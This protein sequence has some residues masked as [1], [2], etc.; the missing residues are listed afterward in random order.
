[1]LQAPYPLRY[2]TS[3]YQ[4][5]NNSQVERLRAAWKEMEDERYETLLQKF[6]KKGGSRNMLLNATD[7]EVKVVNDLKLEEGMYMHAFKEHENMDV[8]RRQKAN[9]PKKR[10]GGRTASQTQAMPALVKMEHDDDVLMGSQA[11][12][13]VIKQIQDSRRDDDRG[14]DGGSDGGH[15]HAAGRWGPGVGMLGTPLWDNRQG[16]NNIMPPMSDHLLGHGGGPGV[17]RR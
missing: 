6:H 5:A 4:V 15:Q 16:V 7:I 2:N 14:D 12:D 9:P 10:S 17:H 1:M 3:K 13:E 11:E 8:R